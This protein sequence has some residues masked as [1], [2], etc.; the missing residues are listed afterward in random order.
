MVKTFDILLDLEKELYSPSSLLFTVSRNDFNSIQLN[1]VITQDGTPVDLTNKTV[2]LAVKKPSG[3]S[4]YQACEIT[5]AKE[6]KAKLALNQQAYI[7]YG[8][9]TAEVYIRDANQLAVTNPFW[10]QS[11]TPILMIQMK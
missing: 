2:E 3:L 6:G 11:R 7:E 9:Y 1:F 4:I 8:I 10:Y 5:S